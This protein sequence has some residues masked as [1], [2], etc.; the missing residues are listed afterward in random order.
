M[1]TRASLA[2]LVAAA[3]IGCGGGSGKGTCGTGG[4][5]AGTGVYTDG[6]GGGEDGHGKPGV[7][8]QAR[9]SLERVAV[10]QAGA[11]PPE[12]PVAVARA[13]EVAAP[14]AGVALRAPPDRAASPAR[15]ARAARL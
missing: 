4:A 8:H 6:T 10:P 15:A 7:H 2:C 13:A 5:T 3:L 9:A 11:E 1:L 12:A 14:A